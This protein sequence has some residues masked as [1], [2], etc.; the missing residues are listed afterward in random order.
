[1][2]TTGNMPMTMP[3]LTKA[4]KKKVMARLAANKRVKHVC[5]CRAIYKLRNEMRTIRQMIMVLPTKPNSSELT[6]KIKSVACSGKKFKCD[7]LPANQPL[8]KAPPEQITGLVP[9]HL[10]QT[11]L[12]P[13]PTTYI[14]TKEN[15]TLKLELG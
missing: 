6:A 13:L 14:P 4:D 11:E 5:A 15:T 7:W 3:M 2:P 12:S 8:P 1:M 9:D 10:N